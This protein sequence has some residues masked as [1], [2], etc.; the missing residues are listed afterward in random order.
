MAEVYEKYVEEFVDENGN[1]D[2]I[3]INPSKNFNFSY[4]ILDETA[5]RFPDDLALVWC[6]EN[7][8]EKKYNFKQISDLS[9]RA[10]NFFKFYGIKKGEFV[11][12]ILKRHSEFW[13]VLNA[14]H[15][16][17]AIAIPATHMLTIDDLKYRIDFAKIQTVVCTTKSGVASKVLEARNKC[18]NLKNLISIGDD[19]EGFINFSKEL[20]RFP[21]KFDRIET[22][23][24][25]PMLAY[26]TSGT[27]GLPK[28][29]IHNYSYPLAHLVTAKYWQKAQKGKLHFTVSDTGWGKAVWGK[30]YGQWMVRAIVMVYDFDKFGADKLLNI[31]EKYRIK[32]FCA[33]PTIY[34]FFIKKG[35]CNHD[36]SS[37]EYVTTAGEAL[38]SNI[39]AEFKRQ[40]GLTIVSA[41]GQ[42]E[43]TAV[44]MGQF[45]VNNKLGSLGK[46]SPLYEVVLLNDEGER[47]KVGE[48][49]EICI[50][51]KKP[52]RQVGLFSVYY[53]DEEL[54]RFVH[55]G[56]FYH[57]GDSAYFDKDGYYFYVGRIDDIIKSSGYRVGPFEIES[58]LVAH[59]AVLEC[60]VLGVFDETRGNVIKAIVVLTDSYE[61]RNDLVKELQNFVKKKTAPYKY[62][63]IIEFVKKLPKT[64]SGKVKRHVLKNSEVNVKQKFI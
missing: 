54:N 34:R 11:L 12:V 9:N 17:G 29:V 51:S 44:L 21:A 15:K 16:I 27:T 49:G 63:R 62:P 23:V 5:R 14:L 25:S 20:N 22:S 8:H 45:P 3:K 36:L 43:T 61:P 6:D 40:T 35:L 55:R 33:P 41:Y 57:T 32:T 47:A 60:A 64:I 37:L 24:E 13:I 10:A 30:L 26:F 1:L 42:T 39:I 56:G 46:P 4:D 48:V 2:R 58:V 28:L 31:I 38:E 50:V 19:V 59:P 18:N 53:N 52:N 7:G